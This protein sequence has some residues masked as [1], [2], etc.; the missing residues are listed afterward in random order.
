MA[1][2]HSMLLK[3]SS[4]HLF[5]TYILSGIWLIVTHTRSNILYSFS[6]TNLQLT[7]YGALSSY[8]D[9]QAKKQEKFKKVSAPRA[10]AHKKDQAS[11]DKQHAR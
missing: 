4:S 10:T 6:H 9:D 7:D 3:F 11:I 2:M 5:G 8:F 1:L